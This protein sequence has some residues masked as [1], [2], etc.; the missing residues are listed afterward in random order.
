MKNENTH[1]FILC[2]LGIAFILLVTVALKEEARFCKDNPLSFKCQKSKGDSGD[3]NYIE[4]KLL[5]ILP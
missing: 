3:I 4:L 2:L 1:L 5:K